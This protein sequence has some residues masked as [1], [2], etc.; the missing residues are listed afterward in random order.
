MLFYKLALFFLCLVMALIF[1]G[2][3][4]FERAL[5]QSQ[6]Y[7][8][9]LRISRQKE[10]GSIL[11]VIEFI[12]WL[13]ICGLNTCT[14]YFGLQDHGDQKHL[15]GL[16]G[17]IVLLAVCLIAAADCIF[18]RIR[19]GHTFITDKGIYKNGSFFPKELCRYAFT[20]SGLEICSDGSRLT[21]GKTVIILNED[22]KAAA[23]EI[24]GRHYQKRDE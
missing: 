7:S 9:I 3:F 21:R 10:K 23:E 14:N 17:W 11:Q 5:K 6:E 18:T 4:L 2:I 1:A 19:Y 20:D 8:E 12:L 24:L 15:Y 13:V 22:E 16:R